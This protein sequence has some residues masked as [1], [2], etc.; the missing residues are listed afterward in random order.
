MRAPRQG[1]QVVQPIRVDRVMGE[2]GF[3]VYC[4]PIGGPG[5]ISVH[6]VI[7]GLIADHR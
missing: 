1:H 5:M 4:V 6:G 7:V 3:G 2:R